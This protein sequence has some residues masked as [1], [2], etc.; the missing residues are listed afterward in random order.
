MCERGSECKGKGTASVSSSQTYGGWKRVGGPL[1][2]SHSV[3]AYTKPTHGLYD[4]TTGTRTSYTAHKQNIMMKGCPNSFFLF[5]FFFFKHK[6]NHQPYVWTYTQKN[7]Q[8][9]LQQ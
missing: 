2:W 5:S 9:W 4:R 8:F 3:H 1:V 6:H 7:E